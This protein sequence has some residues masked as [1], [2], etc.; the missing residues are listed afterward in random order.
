MY[1]PSLYESLM[2]Y[3]C[4]LSILSEVKMI[5]ARFTNNEFKILID[6]LKCDS[7]ANNYQVRG[8]NFDPKDEMYLSYMDLLTMDKIFLPF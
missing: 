8:W 6:V 7:W 4:I 5:W 1:F 2:W 3:V